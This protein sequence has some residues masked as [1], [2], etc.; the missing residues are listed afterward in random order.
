MSSKPQTTKHGWIGKNE[1]KTCPSENLYVAQKNAWME[2]DV[3]MI[4]AEISMSHDGSVIKA[5]QEIM[6]VEVTGDTYP[7]SC[8]SLCQ[9][10]SVQFNKPFKTNICQEWESWMLFEG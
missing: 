1:F 2:K 9:P 3:M 10:V 8:T 7:G 5:I 6:D 4:W